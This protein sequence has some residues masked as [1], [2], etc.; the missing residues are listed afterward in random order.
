LALDFKAEKGYSI[1]TQAHIYMSEGKYKKALECA[2]EA[3]KI[4]S[5]GENYCYLANS[6][7][8]KSHIELYLKDYASSLQTMTA[9]VNIAAIHISQSQAKKFIE[10]YAELLKTCGLR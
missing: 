9:G 7:E 5:D 8:T 3:I 2:N 4:L 10:A 1:D 6:M